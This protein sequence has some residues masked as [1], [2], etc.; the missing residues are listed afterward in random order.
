MAYDSECT[1]GAR[2][3]RE[4]PRASYCPSDEGGG[5]ALNEGR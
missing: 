2:A 5:R 4:R 3:G 1:A